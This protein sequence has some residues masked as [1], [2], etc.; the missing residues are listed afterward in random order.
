ME[1]KTKTELFKAIK[2]NQ[3]DVWNNL[4]NLQHK[5]FKSKH[6]QFHYQLQTDGISCSLLFIRKDLKDK[7]WGSKVPTLQEQD[8]HN[9]E[10][11]SIEQ[12]DTLKDRNIVGC[13]PWK[14]LVSVYDG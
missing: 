13:D 8:F 5:T 4:L 6:F 3:Y 11:L 9:I 12:L 7:N 1:G 10:D 14:A 2:E